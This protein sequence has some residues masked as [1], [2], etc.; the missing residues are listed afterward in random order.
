M[1]VDLQTQS[2]ILQSDALALKVIKDLNLENN[3]DFKPRFNPIG[4]ALSS[5]APSGPTDPANADLDHSPARRSRALKIFQGQLKVKVIAGTRLLEV[6]YS[7]PDPKVAADVVNYLVQALVDYTFQ[8]KFQ[9]TNDV[10]SWLENQL[11]DLRKQSEDLQSRVVALQKST[12]LYGVGGSD[13]QGKPAIYSPVLDS[14]QQATAELSQAQSNRVLKEAVYQVVKTGNAELISQLSGTSIGSSTGQGVTNSLQLVQSLRTQEATL[15]AQIGQDAATFGPAYPKLIE[16]RASLRRVEQSLKDEIGRMATRAK[17]DYEVALRAENGT[18]M[19]YDKQRDAAENQN[20]KTIAYSIL[21]KEAT[22]SQDLYQDLLKRLKEAGILEGLR[23]SNITIVDRAYPPPRPSQPKVLFCLGLGLTFG[24]LFGCVMAALVNII[25]NKVQGVE[26]I[27]ASGIPLMGVLPRIKV[28]SDSGCAAIADE[29]GSMFSEAVRS[30]RAV[31]LIARSGVPPKVIMVTS[32][33][34]GEGKS[35]LSLNLA[36]SLA[37]T[38]SRVLLIEADL[39]RPVLRTRLNLATSE[40]LSSMLTNQDEP[41]AATPSEVHPN[42]W[43]I[44]AG[45]IPPFPTELLGSL[46]MRQ[47]LQQWRKDF[48][49]IVI[50]SP[51]ILPV[52]DARLLEGLADTTVLVVRASVTTRMSLQRAYATLLQHANDQ[53]L[54]AVGAVLNALSLHSAG[55][56]GYYG[57]YGYGK[58]AAYYREGGKK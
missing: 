16:E 15:Q 41:T 56:Y 11:G 7:N 14:L 17:N 5:I 31:L 44:P 45:P 50:D 1:N 55:Y 42:L 9:A 25:D 57:H 32:A 33:N 6:S 18:R 13:S 54:P 39:R 37:Q 8:T 49:F 46:R 20:D 34:P 30:L 43:V 40:G 53:T 58:S 36:V 48:D 3:K 26:E 51:P 23:S 28:V 4:W 12:G 10:S 47:L 29:P 38:Q 52:A 21:N 35:T 2:S 27:E 19:A 22:Q 24:V